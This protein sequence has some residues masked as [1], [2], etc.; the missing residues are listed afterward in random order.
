M[1]AVSGTMDSLLSRNELYACH[2]DNHTLTP[3]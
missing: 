2:I 3:K 1:S